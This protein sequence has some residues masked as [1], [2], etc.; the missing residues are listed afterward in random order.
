MRNLVAAAAALLV[1]SAGT[2]A[3]AEGVNNLLAG[4]N[5]LATFPADP[6]MSFV[7]PPEELEEIF[8]DTPI[9]LS[10]A[11]FCQGTVLMGYRL[12][13]G[14]FDIALFPFWVFPTL[15]PEARY[16]IIPGYEVEYE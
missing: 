7:K 13:M 11:G 12:A 15:S 4:I 1:L 8:G 9:V 16:E 14:V 2:S 5:G 10:L 3:S 6:V